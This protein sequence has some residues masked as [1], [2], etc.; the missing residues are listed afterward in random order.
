M[1]NV[2]LLFVIFGIIFLVDVSDVA[3]QKADRPVK[4]VRMESPRSDGECGSN[5]RVQLRVTFRKDAVVSDVV[6][7]KSSNCRIFDENAIK[8]AKRIK[9]EPAIKD[10][11][12]IT[13]TKLVEFNLSTN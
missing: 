13:V 8:V 4:I 7:V 9:F 2:V 1:R 11:T 10:G 12:E 3:A 5:G 6:V